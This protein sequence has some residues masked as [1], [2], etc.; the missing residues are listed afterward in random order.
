MLSLTARDDINELTAQGAR[1]SPAEVV[2]LNALALKF[3][4]GPMAFDTWALPRAAFCGS[5][6]FR[7]PTLGHQLWLVNISRSFKT[8]TDAITYFIVEAFALSRDYKA[9]PDW[10]DPAKCKKEI[11]RF[12]EKELSPFTMRQVR[13]A[14]SYVQFG[15][16]STALES[17]PPAEKRE[18]YESPEDAADLAACDIKPDTP[19]TV[20]AAILHD[21]LS[22]GL[23]VSIEEAA[24]MTLPQFM[25]L[26]DSVR[27]RLDRD[28]GKSDDDSI[29]AAKVDYW[30]ALEEIRTKHEN[31]ISGNG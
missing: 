21:G 13:N 14:L 11:D 19:R 16:D 10:H 6:T 8:E 22:A 3:E 15:Q 12:V 1:L 26:E 31:E 4:R 7:E 30:R 23:G 28:A 17:P 29:D 24:G 25:A 18:K 2:R 20:W 5:L 9:L 27:R